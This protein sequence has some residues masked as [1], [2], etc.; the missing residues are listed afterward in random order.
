MR[1]GDPDARPKSFGRMPPVIGRGRECPR[2]ACCSRRPNKTRS[3]LGRRRAKVLGHL[4]RVLDGDREALRL[5]AGPDQQEG[6]AARDLA[7][8]VGQ[9]LQPDASEGLD[10]LRS[11]VDVVPEEARCHDVAAP[12][13]PLRPSAQLGCAVA[14]RWAA[15]RSWSASVARPLSRAIFSRVRRALTLRSWLA[16]RFSSALQ[17]GS[18]SAP[19]R[20]AHGPRATSS[21]GRPD[22]NNSFFNG[23]G[24]ERSV[25]A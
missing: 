7:G 19:P 18:S 4:H 22:F 17:P 10:E 2:E 8:L 11:S 15:A 1:R 20:C 21:R 6:H 25:A 5:A 3:G 9:E 23:I 16:A 13:E 24:C 14:C 12:S